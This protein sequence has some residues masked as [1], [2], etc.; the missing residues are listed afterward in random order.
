MKNAKIYLL[1]ILI[2]A[3]FLR[4]YKL[5]EVPVS[6]FG[7]ELDVGYHA[8]SI[9][10]TGRDY[11]GNFLPLHFQSLAEWRTP[12]YLY[13]SV[14]TVGIFGI[15]PLGVRLPASL[16][17]ILSVFA[18]Y[19]L[20]KQ[21]LSSIDNK[22]SELISLCATFV[23]AINPWH[24]QYSRAAFEVTQLLAFLLFGLLFF[25]KGLHK[26]HK[27]FPLSIALLVLT[28]LIYSTAKLFTL[29]FLFV[30]GVVYIKDLLRLPVQVL[31]VTAV[32]G[33]ICGLP[34]VYATIYSGGA[35]R[36]NYISVFSDPT[37][38]PEV[39]T[40]RLQDALVRGEL[41]S[42]L[43]PSFEDRLYH[44]KVVFWLDRISTNYLTSF[45]TDFLFNEGDPN[46]RHSIKGIG[47]FYKIEFITLIIGLVFIFREKLG[48]KEKILLILWILLAVI[49]AS[50]TRDGGNHATRLIVLLPPLAFLIGYGMTKLFT[51]DNKLSRYLFSM[52]YVAIL[53]LQFVFYQHS[54][55]MHN[56]WD[57]E[58]WWHSGW[59]ES[60]QTIKQIEKDYDS[61]YI[62]MTGEPA[63]IFFAGHYQYDPQKWHDGYPMKSA[64]SLGFGEHSYIDKYHFAG[65][66]P[67]TGSIYDLPKYIDSRTLYL[68]NAKEIGANLI[69]EP[70]R[71]PSGLS[72]IQAIPFPSGEPAFYLFTKM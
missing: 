37:I 49:P 9:L 33:F 60:I 58:R 25:L 3:S 53:S 47:Q 71:V 51:A 26:N 40:A 1:V 41:V 45:S 4:L 5:S 54:F 38:E 43:T 66:H 36:F 23:L 65:F 14:P 15:T 50:I 11:S 30:L 12:L 61:I 13:S 70:E 48:K 7:D 63:F 21:M 52:V 24:I 6:L 62:S 46:L 32:V 10:K 57:S 59:K 19:L 27:L 44:N 28:P 35:Q 31:V 42:G 64:S 68:A 22:Q 16:F 55:W 56:P 2:I 72:L 69:Q 67:P 34:T 17:G 29:L 8:Y 18:F 39:G 20:L